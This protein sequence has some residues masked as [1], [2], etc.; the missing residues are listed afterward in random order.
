MIILPAGAIYTD[1][2]HIHIDGN[3]SFGYNSAQGEPRRRRGVE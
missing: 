2:S 3:T 1:E